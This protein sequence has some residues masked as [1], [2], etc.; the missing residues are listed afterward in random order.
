M[1]KLACLLFSMLLLMPFAM[2]YGV[3]FYNP[4]MNPQDGKLLEKVFA[5]KSYTIELDADDLA[6]TSISFKVNKNSTTAGITAY[7]LKSIPTFFP[8]VNNAYE[9]NE[10]KYNGFATHNVDRLT[11]EFNIP[12]E[13][14]TENGV[15]RDTVRYH[16][17]NEMVDAWDEL[18]TEITGEDDTHVFYKAHF[19]DGARYFVIAQA[20][21][22]VAMETPEVEVVKETTPEVKE[23]P[24]A[25]VVEPKEEEV[26]VK[27]QSLQTSVPAAPVEPQS[28]PEPVAQDEDVKS[29]LNYLFYVFLAVLA[30]LVIYWFYSRTPVKPGVDKEIYRYIKESKRH[31]KSHSEIKKRLLD[32]GWHPDRVD[33]ALAKHKFQPSTKVETAAAKPEPKPATKSKPKSKPK[34]KPKKGK[35]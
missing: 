35:K 10:L 31:G 32:V 13:W 19:N 12:K 16:W 1:K 34:K 20:Q 24:V 23:E 15:S 30:V 29:K 4:G 33:K 8:E 18:P 6:I 27:T 7:N 22:E 26:E 5:G 28:T 9:Y 17:H 14:L 25:P 2:A 11:F 21:D 3:T